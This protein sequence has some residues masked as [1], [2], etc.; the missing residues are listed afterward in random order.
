MTVRSVKAV[1]GKVEV[2]DDRGLR[3]TIEDG[4]RIVSVPLS[5][6]AAKELGEILTAFATIH[7]ALE[8]K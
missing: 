8:G 3:I 5:P 6:A 2:D 7:R 4:D 1:Y